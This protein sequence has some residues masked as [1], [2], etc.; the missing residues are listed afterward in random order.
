VIK[1]TRLSVDFILDLMS[2][3][4]TEEKLLTIINLLSKESFSDIFFCSG[5][6]RDEKIFDFQKA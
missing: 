3:G 2:K 6:L 1:N 4:W 5:L